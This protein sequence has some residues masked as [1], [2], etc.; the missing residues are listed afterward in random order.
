MPTTTHH[1]RVSELWNRNQ[2]HQGNHET[3][4]N[5]EY[6]VADLEGHLEKSDSRSRRTGP[7]DLNHYRMVNEVWHYSSVDWG[8]KCVEFSA[9]SP[10]TPANAG[11]SCALGTILSITP[12]RTCRE[13]SSPVDEVKVDLRENVCGHGLS[14]AMMVLESFT[15]ML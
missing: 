15:V 10:W 3:G 6:R 1:S 2:D 11:Q 13:T 14:F 9:F 7:L 4:K 5:L 12:G 8:H